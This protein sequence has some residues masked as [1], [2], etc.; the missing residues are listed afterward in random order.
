VAIAKAGSTLED[1]ISTT[2]RIFYACAYAKK[3]GWEVGGGGGFAIDF[4]CKL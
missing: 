4:R 2:K 3:G 1:P